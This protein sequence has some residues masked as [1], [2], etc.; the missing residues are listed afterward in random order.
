MGQGGSGWVRIGWDGSGW[1]VPAPFHC[2]FPPFQHFFLQFLPFP[3][4]P[5]A[6]LEGNAPK[7]SQEWQ[8]G[9]GRNGSPASGSHLNH[10]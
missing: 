2:F 8:P 9:L 5:N 4:I 1:V 3:Q 10:L 6:H 7:K